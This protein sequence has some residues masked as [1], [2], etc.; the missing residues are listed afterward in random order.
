MTTSS[1]VTKSARVLDAICATSSP[2]SF[3]DVVKASGLPKSSTHRILSILAGEGVLAFDAERQT[4]QPGLRL[5]GWA[6]A[7][8]RL[9]DLPGVAV[10]TM[11]RLGD[12]TGAHV[13]LS[14]PDEVSVLYLKAVDS[15]EP[16]RHAPRVGERSPMHASAAGKTMLAHMLPRQREAALS[17]LRLER[18]TEHT[19]VNRGE[20]LVDLAKA[21]DSG[22]AICDREEFLQVAG[23]AA[24]VFGNN[25]DVA[26][27]ISLWNVIAR[28]D[29]DDLLAFAPDLL[30]AT[31]SLSARLGYLPDGT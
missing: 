18:Y 22:F 6:A 27:A 20:F 9:N 14:V 21:K 25:G 29:V 3:T 1:I 12:L 15:F 17:R 11:D 2:V 28:Q 4:Y 31:A 19:I 26:A 7:A 8:F 30:S 10:A 16:Y 23:I 24:P 13:A 5:I